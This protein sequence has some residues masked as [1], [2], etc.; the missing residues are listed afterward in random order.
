METQN[1]GKKKAETRNTTTNKEQNISHQK[2]TSN[3]KMH[4]IFFKRGPILLIG[5]DTLVG[6]WKI[7]IIS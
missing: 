2:Q 5:A 1:L 7:T 4:R 3:A 6:R